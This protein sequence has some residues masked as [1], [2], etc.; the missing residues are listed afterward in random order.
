MSAARLFKFLHLAYFAKP[1]AYRAV[2]RTI[3]KLCP[4]NLVTIGLGDGQL[5]CNM[6]RLAQQCGQRPRVQLTG[7]DLFEMRAAQEN[8]LT[9][10]HAHRMLHTLG[11]RTRLVPGDPYSALARAANE[12]PDTDLVVVRADQLGPAMQRAWFYLP[13]MLHKQSVVLVERAG[14]DGQVESFDSLD[15]AA[16]LQLAHSAMPVRKAA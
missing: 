12:L 9:L 3:H 5:A 14:G 2:Y 7:I 16:V 13:R 6:V 4:E 8:E 10:K 11:A 15:H 1:V